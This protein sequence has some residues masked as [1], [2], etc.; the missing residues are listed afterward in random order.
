VADILFQLKEGLP[1]NKDQKEKGGN[2]PGD[3]QQQAAGQG[4]G[5]VFSDVRIHLVSVIGYTISLIGK[6]SNGLSVV[7]KERGQTYTFDKID[8]MT[9]CSHVRVKSP[10]DLC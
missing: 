4:K 9:V 6:K 2:N 10:F 7:T 3:T 1:S 5:E 8:G